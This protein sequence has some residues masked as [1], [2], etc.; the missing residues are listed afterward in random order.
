MK[1][2]KTNGE[3]GSALEM[4]ITLGDFGIN[5]LTKI[6]NKIYATGNVITSLC[7]STAVN[8]VQSLL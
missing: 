5:E 7:E 8:T 1:K 3:D 6:L 2:S 4:I